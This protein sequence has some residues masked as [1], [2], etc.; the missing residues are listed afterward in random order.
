[1][2]TSYERRRTVTI[3]KM[4]L[5]N[6]LGMFDDPQRFVLSY[7][8]DLPIGKNKMLLPNVSGFADKSHVQGVYVQR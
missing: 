8:A 6:L 3:K 2:G 1:M 7:V 5:L 4:K